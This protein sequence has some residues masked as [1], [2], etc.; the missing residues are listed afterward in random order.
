CDP[1]GHRLQSLSTGERLPKERA[2]E[3][4]RPENRLVYKSL[5]RFVF[6]C[7]RS[8]IDALADVESLVGTRVLLQLLEITTGNLAV[9]ENC[10]LEVWGSIPHSSTENGKGLASLRDPWSFRG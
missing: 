9:S 2:C 10:T 1:A 7:N 6:R 8:D 4:A 3:R 5:I